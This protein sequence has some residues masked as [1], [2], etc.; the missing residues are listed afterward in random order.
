MM[1]NAASLA[2]FANLIRLGGQNTAYPFNTMR[3]FSGT[4]PTVTQPYSYSELS[5]TGQLTGAFAVTLSDN[6]AGVITFGTTP[7]GVLAT[8]TGT[9]T[10]FALF[11]TNSNGT[12]SGA[13]IGTIG[14]QAAGTAPLQLSTTSLVS[15][16]AIVFSQL[17]IGFV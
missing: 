13:I 4:I 9:A 14:T 2:K 7:T 8:A 17:S 16:T 15:G 6:G 12:N 10:W 3:I 11:N 1:A 5:I